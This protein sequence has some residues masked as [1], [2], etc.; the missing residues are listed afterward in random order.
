MREARGEPHVAG[1]PAPEGK[2]PLT[3]VIGEASPS[4]HLAQSRLRKSQAARP[5][6][7]RRPLSSK[8]AQRS[9]GRPARLPLPLRLNLGQELE[10]EL[11]LEL[12][13][14]GPSGCPRSW[15]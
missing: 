8:S 6:C 5:K 10:L 2:A 1:H 9:I 3:A 15:I 12:T 7:Q 4:L 13:E 14:L 11:E